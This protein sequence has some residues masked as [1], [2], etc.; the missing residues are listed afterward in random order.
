MHLYNKEQAIKRMNQFGQLHR[1]FIFI[2]NYLQDVSY[3]EEVTAV[4]STEVLYNLN[5]FT[6]QIISAEDNIATYSAKTMPSLHW[7]P[8]AESF[9]SYQ[10]SFNIVRQNILAGNSFLT[11]LTCRTPVETNLTLNDIYFHSKAIYKLWIKDRFTVF[12]PEIFIQIHP[13]RTI[14][15][16]PMKG[17]IDA[18]EPDA[19][20][21]ILNDK[22][23]S[24]EHATIVDLIRN[25]LS[26]IAD[27]VTV[28]KYR[29]IDTITTHQG[30]LLQ[31]SSEIKGI[32]PE[33]YLNTLGDIIFKL[34]PAGSI[35]GAPKRKT[36]EII[37]EAENYD[38]GFYTGIMGI[39]DGKKVDSAV[40]IRFIEQNAQGKYLF[41]SGGG[42]TT[43]SK[44]HNE[45]NEI[46]QKIY[47]PIY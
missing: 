25:D 16:Y 35:S 46:K 21:K 3:I 22:K 45:Y 33:N 13:D 41:K 14:Y 40:M 34:L 9:S 44:I 11:N 39:Y 19:K 26:I 43:K 18:N 36:V 29:Y 8:F 12:S 24:A 17:T 38:R 10:R 31:V 1:P 5:G 23:E 47:V 37:T 6:N 32:L 4:D 7:Q 30:K 27:K 42:I 20:Y 28:S 15:S 2:I